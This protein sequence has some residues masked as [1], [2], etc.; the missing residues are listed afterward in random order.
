MLGSFGELRG[1]NR[2]ERGKYRISPQDSEEGCVAAPSWGRQA[3]VTMSTAACGRR[4]EPHFLACLKSVQ[5]F[6]PEILSSMGDRIHKKSSLISTSL[7]DDKLSAICHPWS[8]F[9]HPS[10]EATGSSANGLC[11]GRAL[12]ITESGWHQR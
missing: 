1:E 8:H 4:V 9:C 2:G 7:M 12:D 10:S 5:P 3:P 6:V 11:G